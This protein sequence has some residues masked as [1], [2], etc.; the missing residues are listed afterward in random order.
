MVVGVAAATSP[1]LTAW[2]TRR[3][4][5]VMARAA[6]LYEQRK[7]TYHDLAV[8][9][10]LERLRLGRIAQAV[11]PL[12][13]PPEQD[14]DEDWAML[15]ARAAVRGSDDVQAKLGA[16]DDARRTFDGYA[17]T[18]QGL[19]RQQAFAQLADSWRSVDA[20]RNAAYEAIDELERTMR[21]ELAEL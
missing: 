19:S 1:A 11:G 6:R 16:Y 7:L 21:D 20:A 13:E 9:L 4:E 10:E 8:F 5:Q 3:H 14:T 18:Y 12:P 2:A 17:F 15:R